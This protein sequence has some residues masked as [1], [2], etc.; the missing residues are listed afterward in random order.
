MML[1]NFTKSS[2]KKKFAKK[3]RINEKKIAG[4]FFNYL[5]WLQKRLSYTYVNIKKADYFPKNKSKLK[6][7]NLNSFSSI[8]S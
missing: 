4:S 7:V 6:R 5:F 2:Y 1:K 8:S 3:N